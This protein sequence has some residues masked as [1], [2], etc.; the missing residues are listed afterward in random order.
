MNLENSATILETQRLI[1][2][3][4]QPSDI[5]FLIGLWTDPQVTRYMGGPR[6]SRWLQ[7]VFEET[8]RDP[9]AENYDLWPVVEKATGRLVGHCGLSEKEVEGKTEIELVYTLTPAA[10]G[11]GYATE[12]G[13]AL[14]R[15]AFE[16]MGLE[17]LIALIDPENAPSERVAIRLGMRFE[18]EVLR[19]GGAVRKVY[20]AGVGDHSNGSARQDKI[21]PTFQEEP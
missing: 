8:A 3:R 1:L 18:K 6:E 2:R 9:Y 19:P 5:E 4:L 10:W 20:A 21:Q 13:Q 17:R 12:I 11:K 15:L 7:S 16:K 14:M